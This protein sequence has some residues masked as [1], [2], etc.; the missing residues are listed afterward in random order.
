[1][2]ILYTLCTV[3]EYPDLLCVCYV[4]CWIL[5]IIRRAQ[6]IHSTLSI[7][8][9]ADLMGNVKILHLLVIY[10]IFSANSFLCFFLPYWL[11]ILLFCYISTADK[12]NYSK[13]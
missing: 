12:T 3:H 2:Y 9:P 13:I 11:L 5:R 10:L 4:Y 7:F 1:M 8:P 6:Y